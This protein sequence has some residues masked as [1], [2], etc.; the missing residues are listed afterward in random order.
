MSPLPLTQLIIS[1]LHLHA[2]R[3]AIATLFLDFL[4]SQAR[5]AA[6]LYI[7]GDLFE[8]WPGDDTLNDPAE[9]FNAQICAALKQL[10]AQGCQ[11]Y[12]LPGNRDFLIGAGFVA[13][14]GAT[15][16]NDP[17]LLDLAG[18]PTLLM[19]G[20]LLCSDDTAYLAFR[21]TVRT[22]AWRQE[23][24]ARPLAER[25]AQIEALRQQ[26]E[27]EKQIK[28]AAIMDVNPATLA[29]TLRAQGYPRLIHGHTHRRAHH[30]LRI[31]NHTCERW[32][33]GDWREQGADAG[34]FLRCTP[35]GCEFVLLPQPATTPATPAAAQ[36]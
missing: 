34:N 10:G 25:K 13:A 24:L 7:L 17:T 29:E 4:A 8:Y 1:D 31:D 28:P 2:S 32:V 27:T 5:H 14:T 6:A 23:F 11:L 35:H 20:D 22:P 36:P 3:P 21:A 16:L 19:H 18:V 15:L 26:S 33:L 9:P 12:F 30:K